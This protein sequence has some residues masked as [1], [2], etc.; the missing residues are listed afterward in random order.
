MTKSRFSVDPVRLTTDRPFAN[1]Q[2]AFEQ[3]LGIFDPEVY[4]AFDAWGCTPRF[5]QTTVSTRSRMNGDSQ[6][7]VDRDA[8]LETFAAELA[9][10]ASRVAHRTRTQ[11]TWLDLRSEARKGEEHE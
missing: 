3:R 11:G 4:K 9:P 10:A 8:R 6:T 7:P 2:T 1:V 5:T